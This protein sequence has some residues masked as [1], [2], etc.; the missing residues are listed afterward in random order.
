MI[1]QL[2][3]A[4]F[5]KVLSQNTIFIVRPLF[6]TYK[7]RLIFLGYDIFIDFDEWPAKASKMSK[8]WVADIRSKGKLHFNT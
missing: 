2:W 8:K 6:S 7:T 5:S 3:H 4:V 1:R